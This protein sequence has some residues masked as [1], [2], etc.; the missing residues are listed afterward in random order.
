MEEGRQKTGKRVHEKTGK[1]VDRGDLLRWNLY[2][3]L[4][5]LSIGGQCPPYGQLP[6]ES[7]CIRIFEG[8]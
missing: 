3:T 8:F 5:K 1:V 6:F 2:C 4:Q 7:I